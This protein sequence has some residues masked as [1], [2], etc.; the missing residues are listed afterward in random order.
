M[1]TLDADPTA[2]MPEAV[3]RTVTAGTPD[4]V[5]LTPAVRETWVEAVTRLL[6]NTDARDRYAAEWRRVT[7]ATPLPADL[8]RR[9]DEVEQPAEALCREGVAVLGDRELVALA[10]SPHALELLAELILDLIGTDDLGEVWRAPLDRAARDAYP[11]TPPEV[12]ARLTEIARSH[13]VNAKVVPSSPSSGSTRHSMRAPFWFATAAAL[14]VGVGL[15]VVGRGLIPGGGPV[16]QWAA[17]SSGSD[18]GRLQ[19]RG[20]DV[21]FELKLDSPRPGFASV[22]VPRPADKPRVY[23]EGWDDP[24][25]VVPGAA[26]TYGP[27]DARAGQSVL[28]VVTETPAADVLRRAFDKEPLADSVERLRAQAETVLKANGFR[29]AA[30]AVVELK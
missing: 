7:Q 16:D 9:L 23:P 30:F 24:P 17:L 28:V 11:D 2:D 15:G 18:V 22:I 29:W 12:R 6:V 13:T 26:A 3:R 19:P 25:R 1:T 21:S 5:R 14:L 20:G 4:D 10:A 8:R 27:L